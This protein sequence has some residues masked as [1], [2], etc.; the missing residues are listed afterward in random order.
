MNKLNV[1]NIHTKITSN[2]NSENDFP[3]AY[4]EY[5][6]YSFYRFSLGF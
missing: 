3:L 2:R 6:K 1:L 4:L 5:K